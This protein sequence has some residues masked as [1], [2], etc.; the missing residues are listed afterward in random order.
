MWPEILA[1]SVKN[2]RINLQIFFLILNEFS[3]KFVCKTPLDITGS[4]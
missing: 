1:V 4:T 3:N 2:I